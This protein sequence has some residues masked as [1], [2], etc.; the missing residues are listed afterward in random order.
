MDASL[1]YHHFCLFH[2]FLLLP[3]VLLLAFCWIF[4]LSGKYI[5]NWNIVKLTVVTNN[6]KYIYIVMAVNSYDSYEG[7]TLVTGLVCIQNV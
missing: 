2:S 7:Q 5:Y 4:H 1:R 3:F 6:E